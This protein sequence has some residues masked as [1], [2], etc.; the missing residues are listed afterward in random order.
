M[1]ITVAPGDSLPA[2]HPAESKIMQEGLPTAYI[3]GGGI[4]SPPVTDAAVLSQV[5]K[6]PEN[7]PFTRTAGNA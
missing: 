6:L 4:C 7:S 5:L 1:L 3:C 2:G